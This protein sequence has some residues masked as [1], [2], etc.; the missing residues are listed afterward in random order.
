[1][2][3]PLPLPTTFL[4]S[5]Y[6]SIREPPP[7]LSPLSDRCSTSEQPPCPRSTPTASA[8]GEPRFPMSA[9]HLYTKPPSGVPGSEH[10]RL[11]LTG[12]HRHA[13]PVSPPLQHRP[14]SNSATCTCGS[15]HTLP[16][17]PRPHLPIT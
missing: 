5:S 4:Q 15:T 9:L 6:R 13:V 17:P 1:S 12:L 16:G 7:R 3:L 2:L 8:F 10:H 11:R 14:E